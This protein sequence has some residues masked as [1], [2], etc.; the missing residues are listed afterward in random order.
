MSA[1]Q[2]LLAAGCCP[3]LQLGSAVRA[4][5]LLHAVTGQ[6][7]PQLFTHALRCLEGHLAGARAHV[8]AAVQWQVMDST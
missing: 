1:E 5:L 7:Q 6:G 8:A 3:H 4:A 2:R